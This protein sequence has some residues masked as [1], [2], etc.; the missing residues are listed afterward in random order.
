MSTYRIEYTTH[1]QIKIKRVQ[2]NHHNHH[3]QF[4]RHQIFL[5][6]GKYESKEQ[7]LGGL[8]NL[9]LLSRQYRNDNPWQSACRIL[10]SLLVVKWKLVYIIYVYIHMHVCI[11]ILSCLLYCTSHVIWISSFAL[12]VKLLNTTFSLSWKKSI[13]SF[14]NK[15]ILSLYQHIGLLRM[16]MMANDYATGCSQ[17]RL[18]NC[19][20]KQRY[21]ERYFST[22]SL[23]TI[24]K[25]WKSIVRII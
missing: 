25:Q 5:R 11:C 17:T 10:H 9:T 18:R 6:N 14:Q 8:I 24:I 16:T 22:K 4:C 7:A 15:T 19:V 1:M 23:S 13:N 3:H 20:Q 2:E 21:T 12:W